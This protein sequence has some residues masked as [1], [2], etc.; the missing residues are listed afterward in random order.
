MSANRLLLVCKHCQ[1]IEDAIC[2]G[3]RAGN[4][5]QYLASS[6]K[7]LDAWFGKHYSCG[8]GPDVFALAY[9]RTPNW[10]ISPPAPAAAV[11]VRLALANE[12]KQ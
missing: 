8:N 11:G 3:E 5:V 1:N 6:M 2:V 7:K 4:D 12:T 10:D 9:H